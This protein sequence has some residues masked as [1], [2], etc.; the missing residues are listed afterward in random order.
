MFK[1]WGEWAPA[2]A[3][4]DEVNRKLAEVWIRKDGSVIEGGEVDFFG[5]DAVLY[6]A[7]KKDAGRLLDGRTWDGVPA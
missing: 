7:G 5:G 1:Q 2:E 4:S 3:I 6:R